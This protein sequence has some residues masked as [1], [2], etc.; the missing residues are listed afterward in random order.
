MAGAYDSAREFVDDIVGFAL[1]L[2]ERQVVAHWE[3]GLIHAPAD[4]AGFT[5]PEQSKIL[6]G[7]THAPSAHGL[8]EL[9]RLDAGIAAK[10]DEIVERLDR[11]REVG[12]AP[13]LDELRVRFDLSPTQERALWIVLA[14]ELSPRV[15]QL[16]RYLAQDPTRVLPDVGLLDTLVYAGGARDRYLVDLGPSGPLFRYRLLETQ[17]GQRG[18]EPFVTRPLRVSPRVL[19]LAAGE[20]RLDPGLA[21]VAE[22][23]AHPSDG[24]ELVGLAGAI[25][26]ATL[27]VGEGTGVGR[28][29]PLIVVSGRL[30]SGR[31]AVLGAAAR[32][33]R[34]GL[35]RIRC[36]DLP[37]DPDELSEA[38]EALRREATLLDALPVLDEIEELLPP[39]GDDRR[40]VRRLDA[41][42]AAW[43]GPVAAT[44]AGDDVGRV[45]LRRGIV[46]VDLPPL[47][48]SDRAELWR[49]EL[50]GNAGRGVDAVALAARYPV[51]PG[52]IQRAAAS[53]GS[54]AT[55][56]GE[57]ITDADVH[58]GL[59]GAME[60]RILALGTRVTW[61]QRWE[62]LVLPDE[63]M[64]ALREFVARIRHR[65]RVYDEWGF[66]KK[67]AKGL[68]LSA[69]LSG[70]PGTGKTMVAGIIA[71][72]LGLDLYQIE[73]SRVVSKFIGETEKN[74]ARIFDAAEAGAS[75]LLFDEADSLF[76]QRA[77][78][79]SSNDRYAN[80]E[81]NYLLQRME[82]FSGI[83]I[84]TTNLASSIDPA[85][86][87]RIA[88][89]IEFPMPEADERLRLWRA[90]LPA[91]AQLA[92]DIDFRWLATRFEMSGGHIRNSVLRAAFLAADDGVRIGQAHMRR[93]A[94]LEYQ[95]MGKVV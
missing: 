54:L 4:R 3:Y 58:A 73:V 2:I 50:G 75:I 46:R 27:L 23:V 56:R 91:T 70:P 52:T 38:L 81:V 51:T 78:V 57:P 64:D 61:S 32:A 55:A 89:T 47:A 95:A 86:K 35:L 30:G 62:D 67:L 79:K 19:D 93:A 84:L 5:P 40:G 72:Q 16:M 71:G 6:M 69:L 13:P 41:A 63:I 31:K 80:L 25:T 34:K 7:G 90:H 28:I 37:K 1:K 17:G 59:R 44:A 14:A 66:A 49:R 76:S 26:T 45:L 43:E 87:R 11:S 60:E 18:R 53:A 9:A 20:L 92:D 39:D 33:A 21:G 85:F 15:R 65:R 68:G 88:F 12:A 74:L 22:L 42:L 77:E 24:A 83:T 48:E 29:T 8:A 36:A 10:S 82:R 94:E